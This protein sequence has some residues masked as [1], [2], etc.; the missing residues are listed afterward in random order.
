MLRI[1]TNLIW[2]VVNL[3]I[4]FILIRKF[5]F[6]P[7]LNIIE[8]RK[9]MIEEQFA[10]AEIQNRQALELK[11]KYET[12]LEGAKEES[13]QLIE[14]AR[15]RGEAE[16][17]QIVQQ[18]EERA[19]QLMKN[20]DAS[21]KREREKAL[22]DVQ[23]EISSLAMAAAMKIIGD[24]SSPVTDEGFYNEFLA[25]AGKQNDADCS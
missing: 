19:G 16:Y 15:Q 18:A 8:K 4:F 5:L 10:K 14:D 1:D 13:I 11:A 7:V 12:S 21:L 17:R 6:K 2:I 9:Q 25:K 24:A 22:Q 20:A 3:I 23:N